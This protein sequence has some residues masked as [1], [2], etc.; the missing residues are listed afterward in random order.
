MKQ[1]I[2][3]TSLFL[4][5][6]AAGFAQEKKVSTMKIY[7]VES[8]TPEQKTELTKEEELKKCYDLLEALDVKEAWIRSNPEE[9][10]VAEESG[11]FEDAAKTR[12]D[13]NARI[14]ELESK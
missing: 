7:R 5:M 6:G 2:L 13:V 8:K 4:A 10:K 11:W 12:A 3:T 9:L 1:V 14:K